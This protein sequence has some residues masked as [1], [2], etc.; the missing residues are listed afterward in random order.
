[1]TG[2][3]L[4]VILGPTGVGKT[5]L[6]IEIARALNGEIVGADSRQVYR[7]MDIGTGKP[8]AAQCAAVPHH[9]LDV[10]TP[11][12]NLTLA[13]YQKLAY[14]AVDNIQQRGKLPLLVGGT[15]QYIT[16]VVEGWSIPEVPPDEQLR[17]ELEAFA[18]EHGAEQLFARL[19]QVDAEAAANIDYRN[20]RRVIRAIEVHTL[21][22]RKFSELQRKTPPPYRM[23]HIGLTMAEREQVYARADVRVDAMI[24]AGFVDE[25][26]RLLEMGYPRTLP[27]M[28]GL[29]YAQLAAYLLD[30]EALDE[31]IVKTKNATHDF[32]RRQYTWFRGHDAGSLWH[33]VEDVQ[34]DVLL[35]QIEEFMRS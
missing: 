27:S 6:G 23:M 30:G 15:G 16:A 26:R 4:I 17:A 24:A 28:S 13:R 8:D 3:P 18:A 32:I 20:L 19:R 5:A 31:A 1:M 25:V 35:R 14:A 33:N 10:V 12:D 2:K 21:T 11:D 29:G 9:L 7:Y 34:T 22:G